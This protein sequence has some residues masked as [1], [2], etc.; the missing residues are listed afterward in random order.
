VPSAASF[1]AEVLVPP[2]QEEALQRFAA[3]LQ[4]RIVTP[5]SLLVAERSAPLNE[6][7]PL[8]RVEIEMLALDSSVVSGL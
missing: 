2:G 4:S 8:H 1:V 5:D 6:P 3:E 7:R